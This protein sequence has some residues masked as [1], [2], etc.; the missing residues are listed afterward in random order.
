MKM[1]YRENFYSR[2]FIF[3][4]KWMSEVQLQDLRKQLTELGSRSLGEVPSY[5]VYLPSRRPYEN[6]I[7]TVT[8]SGP[9]R[10]PVAFAAMV[11]WPVKLGN[12]KRPEKI[13]HLGLVVVDPEYRGRMVM[14]GM[15]HRPLTWYFLRRFFR[16][17]WISSTTM[18]PVIF[19]SVADN[20]SRVFPHYL[21]GK[22]EEPT[23]RQRR[24]A[25][26]FVKE[27]GQEIGI[28]EGAWLDAE[29]FIIR[30]SSRGASKE[31]MHDYEQT[32][33]YRVQACNE[34][35]RRQLDYAEGDE[36]IQVGRVDLSATLKSLWWLR[37]KLLS[38]RQIITQ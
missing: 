20:F 18:E 22:Q 32:A 27:Q 10:K 31:L 9:D 30:G 26:T 12:R 33:K 36:F 35:C 38:L 11:V 37:K 16:P 6:R 29:H 21:P 19:G 23:P 34:F 14:Y 15:Y 8:Y 7:I 24:I 2:T 13:V 25:E 3:P 28:A 17:F 4:G 5:G 1:R